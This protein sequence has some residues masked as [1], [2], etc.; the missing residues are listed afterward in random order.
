MLRA[1]FTALPVS[2]N[3]FQAYAVAL[4]ERSSCAS[5]SLGNGRCFLRAVSVVDTC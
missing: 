1:S 3:G 4:D 2:G 5:K